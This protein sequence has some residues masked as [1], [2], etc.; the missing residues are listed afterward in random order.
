M[1]TAIG[2][3][4]LDRDVSKFELDEKGHFQTREGLGVGNI[5]AKTYRD[6]NRCIFVDI[7]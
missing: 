5:V 3:L 1:P 6:Q 4:L 7:A 2:Y